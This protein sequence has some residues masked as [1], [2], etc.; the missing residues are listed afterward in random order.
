[1][2]KELLAIKVEKRGKYEMIC[3]E[4]MVPKDHMLKNG[5]RNRF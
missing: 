3:I 1:M 2:E 5:C 4:E